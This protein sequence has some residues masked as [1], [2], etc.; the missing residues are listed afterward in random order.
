VTWLV[1]WGFFHS[2]F[3]Y[4]TERSVFRLWRSSE[5]PCS[6]EKIGYVYLVKKENPTREVSGFL[7]LALFEISA[8]R[9]S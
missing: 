1:F 9:P 6:F 5:K 3:S 4:L 7:W 2:A 8:A